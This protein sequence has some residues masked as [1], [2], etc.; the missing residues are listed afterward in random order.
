MRQTAS[1]KSAEQEDSTTILP[2][3]MEYTE[4]T[5]TRLRGPVRGATGAVKFERAASAYRHQGEVT[6]EARGLLVESRAPSNEATWT[7][8]KANARKNT[9]TPFRRP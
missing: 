7:R 3:P 2:W 9:E 4:G 5:V 8:V 6:V 1:F